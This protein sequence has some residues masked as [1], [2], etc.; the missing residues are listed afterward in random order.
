MI[1]IRFTR[2]AD[3]RTVLT[4]VRRDASV[5]GMVEDRFFVEHDLVHYAVETI[6]GYRQGF[7]GL[8]ASGWDIAAFGAPDPSSGAKP[9][10]PAEAIMVEHLVGV[11]QQV[12]RGALDPWDVSAALA[13][14]LAGTG[15][16]APVV[17][18]RQVESIIGQARANLEE[19]AELHPGATLEL[20]FPLARLAHEAAL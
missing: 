17:S 9:A 12:M 3:G 14:S 11:V 1:R 4:C 13:M 5:T 6:L 16:A 20:P 18:E 8:L 10:V 2:K 19:W 15:I 7:Y